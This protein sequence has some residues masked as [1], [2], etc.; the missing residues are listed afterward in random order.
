M[1]PGSQLGARC[2][3]LFGKGCAPLSP[4]TCLSLSRSTA[5]VAS[6]T[7]RILL[8]RRSARASESSCRWPA[9]QFEALS[10]TRASRPP[11]CY[12]NRVRT[13]RRHAAS[14][15]HHCS[16]VSL[17]PGLLENLPK[18]GVRGDPGW[19]EVETKGSC[20]IRELS[21]TRTIG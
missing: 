7:I 21:T 16:N 13:T 11:S 9:D 19:V 4:C 14:S 5:L 20:H 2:E 10:A 17:Q 18:L 6:S 8:L 3:L 1:Q 12:L 15:A